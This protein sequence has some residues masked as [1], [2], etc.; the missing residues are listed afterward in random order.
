MTLAEKNKYIFSVFEIVNYLIKFYNNSY[1]Q[2]NKEKTMDKNEQK[3]FTKDN[4]I[5]EK[6]YIYNTAV[7]IHFYALT[8]QGYCENACGTKTFV[9]CLEEMS[10]DIAELAFKI[11]EIV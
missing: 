5:T 8:M 1:R 6:E 2:K 7:K 10:K 3:L 9:S 11:M 4:S